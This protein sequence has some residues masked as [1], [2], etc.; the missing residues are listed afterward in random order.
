[1]KLRLTAM[2]GGLMLLATA[3]LALPPMSKTFETTYTPV[4]NG[5]LAKAKCVVCHTAPGKTSLNP[6][7]K[8]L[9]TELKGT[10]TLTA[11][12]L[13]AVEAKDS[14][15]DGTSNIDEIKADFLPGDKASTPPKK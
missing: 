1:M 13:K 14:D 9:K 10:K 6:F 8:D 2:A 15:G 5:K 12:N 7:G 11:A 3:A 4:K